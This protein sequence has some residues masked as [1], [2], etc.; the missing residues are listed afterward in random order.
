MLVMW[1]HFLTLG[2]VLGR[3]FIKKNVKVFLFSKNALD[4]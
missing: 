1:A 2:L 4:W 3:V